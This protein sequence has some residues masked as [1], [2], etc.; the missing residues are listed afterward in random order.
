MSGP[1]KRAET[2]SMILSSVSTRTGQAVNDEFKAVLSVEQDVVE[3]RNR[4][5]LQILYSSRA[6][7][8]ALNDFL[9]RRYDGLG[10]YISRLAAD[11][12]LNPRSRDYY[13]EKISDV[14][15]KYLHRAGEYPSEK[16]VWEYI[17][18]VQS[19][20]ARVFA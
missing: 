12:V 10:A 3:L 4:H 19:C 11:G 2:I 13:Q 6:L 17:S 15:N 9:G 16:V 1:E 20:L 8:K 7:E 14:R 5:L 18:E